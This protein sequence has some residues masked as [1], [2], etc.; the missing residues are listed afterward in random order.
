MIQKM[1]KINF[2]KIIENNSINVLNSKISIK[3]YHLLENVRIEPTVVKDYII[4]NSILNFINFYKYGNYYYE[5]LE[6]ENQFNIFF[7]FNINLNN[8]KT[9]KIDI[10]KLKKIIPEKSKESIKFLLSSNIFNNE[11]LIK[12]FLTHICHDLLNLSYQDEV[13][14]CKD[15][16]KNIFNLIYGD[17]FNLDFLGN[18]NNKDLLINL[19]DEFE[20]LFQYS[21]NWLLNNT[22]INMDKGID[23][24]FHI[25]ESMNLYY[26]TTE[27]FENNHNK[28][29]LNSINNNERFSDYN[30]I[31]PSILNRLVNKG[32][33]NNNYNYDELVKTFNRFFLYKKNKSIFH[34]TYINF[35]NNEILDEFNFC[36]NFM[37][38]NKSEMKKNQIDELMKNTFKCLL[39]IHNTN[40]YNQRT[41][42][43]SDGYNVIFQEILNKIISKNDDMFLT[44]Y[45]FFKSLKSD[46]F[47]TKDYLN[48][49]NNFKID[50]NS[51]NYINNEIND[52]ELIYKFK[53]II[54]NDSVIKPMILLIT[55]N[56]LF[57][58]RKLESY[59]LDKIKDDKQKVTLLEKFSNI[60]QSKTDYEE[61]NGLHFYKEIETVNNLYN[62]KKDF[63]LIDDL[64]KTVEQNMNNIINNFLTENIFYKNEDNFLIIQ[65]NYISLFLNNILFSAIMSNENVSNEIKKEDF[66]NIFLTKYNDFINFEMLKD[67]I[68]NNMNIMILNNDV[69]KKHII[70]NLDICN[71]KINNLSANNFKKSKNKIA[72]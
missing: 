44:N 12:L 49:R 23:F 3:D 27:M 35:S 46:I 22:Y 54:N 16:Y 14:R 64:L 43:L 71:K 45:L 58:N 41:L 42:Y 36:L 70:E 38:N 72:L 32:D 24:L 63:E 18:E 33:E 2:N 11:H 21:V 37:K 65:E 19:K 17:L 6:I 7:E 31:K 26:K 34:G 62:N 39:E 9:E 67:I 53:T 30:T 5:E 15:H 40:S 25:S 48:V 20:L 10:E 55:G 61:N 69:S 1:T 8:L 50:L 57:I 59:Y 13:V 60:N 68:V 47:E 28:I 4:L 56:R 29:I 52:S 51:L 66:F